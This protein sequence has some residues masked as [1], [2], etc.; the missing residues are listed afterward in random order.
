MPREV[1]EQTVAECARLEGTL[2]RLEQSGADLVAAILADCRK[3]A[4]WNMVYHERQINYAQ[5]LYG[6]TEEHY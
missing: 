6:D 2:T 3:H 4:H 5:T 1:W